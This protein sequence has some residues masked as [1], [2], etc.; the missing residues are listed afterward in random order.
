MNGA[1]GAGTAG[2]GRGA[3]R[4]GSEAGPQAEG[5]ARAGRLKGEPERAAPARPDTL[6]LRRLRNFI[7]ITQ[8]KLELRRITQ[9]R[10]RLYLTVSVH[11]YD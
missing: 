1:G 11:S 10:E 8:K 3:G 9:K 2:P 5:G 7:Q 6:R 4:A